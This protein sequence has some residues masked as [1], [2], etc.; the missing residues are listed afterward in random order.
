MTTGYT[1][2]TNGEDL[3]FVDWMLP[4]MKWGTF[5]Q[6]P[7]AQISFTF[8]VTDY[9]GQ[10]P[11]VYGPYTA[12]KQTPYIS[13]RF[14]GRFVSLKLESNDLGSFWRLGSLRYRFAPSGRR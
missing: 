9:A 2:L 5:S 14:R 1:S 3:I 13:P 8:N 12:T 6:P 7:D 4:D 11:R 10:N